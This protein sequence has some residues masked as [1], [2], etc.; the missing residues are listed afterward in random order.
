[1]PA[2]PTVTR[3]LVPTLYAYAFL[4]E[5]VLLY[6]LYTLLFVRT[7]L[8]TGQISSL[9][10]LWSLTTLTLEV[11]AGVWADAVSR[12]LLLCLGPLLGAFGFGLWVVA[13]SYPA[14]AIG[15]VLWG[16]KSALVS[17]AL[18]ALV[19]EELAQDGTE[20]RFA[21][22]WGR[23]Q[24]F[25]VVAVLLAIVLASPVVAVGGDTA[26]GAASVAAGGAGAPV[27]GA[28]PPRR[29]APAD[30]ED[31]DAG[32]VE[33]IRSGWTLMRADRRVLRAVL[34]VPAI[35]SIFM[36]LEEYT[37]LLAAAGGASETEV[38]WWEAV[39][40]GG[41]TVGGLIAGRFSGLR[42]RGFAVLVASAAL[43]LVAGAAT[44][45][46][47]GLVLVAVAFGLLQVGSVLAQ[48]RLQ[49]SMTGAARATVTSLASLGDELGA[50]P[51]YLAY[52]RLADAGGDGLAFAVLAVPYLVIAAWIAAERRSCPRVA[53]VTPWT[54]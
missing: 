35:A 53:R 21:Q 10:V 46:A 32:Y 7:G 24:A 22:V 4:D 13:P 15:F 33:T 8:S 31:D 12:R 42:S 1:M 34:L 45:R 49:E 14:F 5:F 26:G 41:L 51:V 16:A 44:G 9:F 23:A 3:R 25:G 54:S 20:D 2:V 6:P 30:A 27:A 37:P 52:G 39:V 29:P 19:Y 47:A 43:V 18:E 40:W 36:A 28:L 17:G 50:L 38:P 11:P 48:T